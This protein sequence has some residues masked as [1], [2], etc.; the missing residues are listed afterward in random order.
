[1]K[2]TLALSLASLMLILSGIRLTA[3]RVRENLSKDLFVQLVDVRMDSSSKRWV[4]TTVSFIPL[5]HPDPGALMY[6]GFKFMDDV[7]VDLFLCFENLARKE[8]WRKVGR[9]VNPSELYDYFHAS[10]EIRTLKVDRQRNSL[11]FLIPRTIAERDGYDLAAIPIGHVFEMTVGGTPLSFQ[12]GVEFTLGQ[13]DPRYL[14]KF[15]EQA[16]AKAG[17]NKGLLLP[18]HLIYPDKY[19]EKAPS[20]AVK[21]L[22]PGSSP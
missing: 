13:G 2:T 11:T 7:K 10:V 22:A 5:K 20:A 14:A 17:A 18:A 15:K 19:L 4:M 21:I 12:K 9:R 3:Q 8:A 16:K 6:K 1:M